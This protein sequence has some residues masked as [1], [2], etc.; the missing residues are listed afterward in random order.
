MA[1]IKRNKNLVIG[2]ALNSVLAIRKVSRLESGIYADLVFPLFHS[3]QLP[4]SHAK[5]PGFAI[6]RGTIRYQVRCFRRCKEVRSKFGAR[7]F[8]P[9]RAGVIQHM[10]I[11]A[12]AIC[13]AFSN[14]VLDVGVAELPLLRSSPLCP[15][16]AS[17]DLLQNRRT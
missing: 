5:P 16:L 7:P 3:F 2:C 10:Q 1:R 12:L 17:R 11:A 15:Q 13:A 9:Q 6:I 8:S 4:L 14:L